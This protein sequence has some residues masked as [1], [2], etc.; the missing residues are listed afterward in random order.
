MNKNLRPK[1]HLLFLIALLSCFQTAAQINRLRFME[2]NVENLFD[3]IHTAPLNDEEFTPQAE[4]QWNSARYWS[5]LSR[6]SRVIAAVGYELPPTWVAMVEVENDSVITH[7]IRRTKLWTAGYDYVMT[8]SPDRRGINVVL[9]YLPH[10]FR[11]ISHDSLRI[12]PPNAKMPPTRDMLHVA[13][14]LINGDT[15]DIWVVHWPSRRN[16][17]SSTNYRNLA[18]RQLRQ[19][20]DSVMHTRQ[21][22]QVIVTGDFNAFFPEPSIMKHLGAKLPDDSTPDPHALYLLSAKMRASHGI[23]GTYRYQGVW[24]QLDNFIVNGSLLVRQRSDALFTAR[25]HCRI[26]DFPFLLKGIENR[27]GPYPRRTYLGTFHQGGYSDHLP[28]VLDLFFE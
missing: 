27:N 7:L 10:Q 17:K 5:K 3:T 28:L 18:A 20:I 6:L 13:G 21:T 1:F 4:R 24:D 23:Q 16:G 26:A 14:E 12:V 25:R 2:Y 8:H 19:H 22:P 9:L 11:P 15:L